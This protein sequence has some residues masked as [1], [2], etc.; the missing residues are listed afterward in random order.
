[1][2]RLDAGAMTD[3][4][5]DMF[6]AI[7]ASRAHIGPAALDSAGETLAA[8]LPQGLFLGTSSWSFPGWAGLVY[9]RQASSQALARDGLA[10]YARLG[11]FRSVCI[12]RGYYGPLSV[13]DFRRYADAVPA[14]FRFMVKADGACTQSSVEVDGQWRANPRFLDPGHASEQVVAPFVEGLGRKAGVLVFQFPP[15]TA[16]YRR[17]PQAFAEHLQRFLEALPR[18]PTY[19]VEIRD[20]FLLGPWFSRAIRETDGH[21][22]LSVHPRM[23]SIAKQRD[24]TAAASCGPLIVRWNL[25]RAQRYEAARERYAPFNRLVDEDPPTRMALARLARETL[26]SGREV[27]IIANNKAEGSA[28]LTLLALGQAVLARH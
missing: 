22:C 27:F 2:A 21:V 14:D 15:V 11:P 8:R 23:P 10:A 4:Q 12:D 5:M 28:P 18:G 20:H 6:G 25:H 13:A 26:A 9:D 7:P 16:E 17:R 1:M 3:T 24:M 19:A